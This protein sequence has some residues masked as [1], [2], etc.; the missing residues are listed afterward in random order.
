MEYT[1]KN[2]LIALA[3]FV[4]CFVPDVIFL[5][6]VRNETLV[7]AHKATKQIYVAIMEDAVKNGMAV[8]K[9]NEY[10][11]VSTSNKVTNI[12]PVPNP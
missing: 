6:H 7:W 9:N 5:R 8:K 1:R 11:W 10:Y 4:L 12:P 2:I 3:I